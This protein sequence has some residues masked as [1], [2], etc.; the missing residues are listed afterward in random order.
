MTTLQGGSGAGSVVKTA[1]PVAS[2]VAG[3]DQLEIRQPILCAQPHAVTFRC[4][5]RFQGPEKVKIVTEDH[6]LPLELGL[7]DNRIDEA[8]IPDRP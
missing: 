4:D 1:F 5:E 2:T 6:I 8:V 3:V 7:G